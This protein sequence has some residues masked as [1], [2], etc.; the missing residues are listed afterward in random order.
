MHSGDVRYG[1]TSAAMMRRAERNTTVA[2]RV[3][4]ADVGIPSEVIWAWNEENGVGADPRDLLDLMERLRESA[5]FFDEDGKLLGEGISSAIREQ[6][7]RLPQTDWA[8]KAKLRLLAQQVRLTLGE[9][10]LL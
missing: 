4:N 2:L 8:A 7:D 10:G 3:V 1:E 9:M 5:L 6:A